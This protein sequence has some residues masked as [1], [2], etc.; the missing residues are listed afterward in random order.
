[1]S[2]PAS[3]PE[4][5]DLHPHSLR[6]DMAIIAAMDAVLLALAFGSYWL[7]LRV[8]LGA[9]YLTLALTFVLAVIATVIAGLLIRRFRV[10][11]LGIV[12]L[13]IVFLFFEACT[14]GAS[15]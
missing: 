4:Q 15:V 11:V 12:A 7:A 8:S 6:R 10:G 3:P 5:Q 14:S 13:W 9:G 2:A 1:M